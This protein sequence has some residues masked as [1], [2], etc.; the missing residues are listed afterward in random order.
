[1]ELLKGI[2]KEKGMLLEML[3][4]E[5]NEINKKE[6][7]MRGDVKG[8]WKI[9]KEKMKEYIETNISNIK[10][11][12]ETIKKIIA[13]LD[14]KDKGGLYTLIIDKN[15]KITESI[16][17][18]N[19]DGFYSNKD[20]E[21]LDR[22]DK[23]IKDID[24]LLLGVQ[25]KA[26]IPPRVQEKI[27]QEVQDKARSPPRVQVKSPDY[28]HSYGSN[29][30]PQFPRLE[31]Y[32]IHDD[33][34]AELVLINAIGDGDCFINAIFDYGLYT[35][36]LVNIYG[37][38][39]HLE[40]LI[41]SI[42]KYQI[43][44]SKA[45]AL[46]DKKP[47]LDI[48]T[49][50]EYANILDPKILIEEDSIETNN[51]RRRYNIATL[52]S[53]KCF[54][55]PYPHERIKFKKCVGHERYEHE[56][57]KFIKFMKYM[58]VLYTYTFGYKLFINILK[59]S[60]DLNIGLENLDWDRNLINMVKKT[61]YDSQGKRIHPIDFDILLDK[62]MDI[63]VK[64]NGFFTCADQILIF[65]KIFFKKLKDKKKEYNIPRFWLNC[66]TQEAI[67]IATK[68]FRFKDLGTPYKFSQNTIDV[69]HYISIIK[70]G[71]H[72]KLFV[73]KENMVL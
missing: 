26:K 20:E 27:H 55:H 33:R 32:D 12:N 2:V 56:R 19:K 8:S 46:F 37:R 38:L 50:E 70:D 53:F 63:Y 68:K 41:T 1:M 51:L 59:F 25:E 24:R 9:N 66:D 17:I 34:N 22:N 64:T 36:T 73:Y 5:T 57:L 65:R 16:E 61:Y 69:Y 35:G 28:S 29:S 47:T 31:D 15:D 48:L 62:Y 14:K 40:L 18:L 52:Q 67:N 23:D 60:M 42:N 49:D 44:I 72:F 39:N 30:S 45:K 13:S 3:R 71:A 54:R 4:T 6:N 43:S 7:R 11:L 10:K 58:H 21:D